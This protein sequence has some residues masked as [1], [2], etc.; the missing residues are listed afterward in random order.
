MCGVWQGLHAEGDFDKALAGAHGREEVSVPL[1][2]EDVL[3]SVE[4]GSARSTQSHQEVS[5]CLRR[6][7]P[8]LHEAR[9]V[10]K[11]LRI[12]TSHRSR[13]SVRSHVSQGTLG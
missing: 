3:Q 2:R 9:A 1:L 5:A 7:W 4:P 10:E 8:R 6:L 12:E 11:T 13:R